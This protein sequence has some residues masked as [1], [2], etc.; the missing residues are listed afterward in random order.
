MSENA[1]FPERAFQAAQNL[2]RRGAEVAKQQTRSVSLQRQIAKAREQKRRVFMQMGLKVY[3]L[4][5]KELVKNAELRILCQQVTSL[6]AEI[7]L[8]EE[9]LDQLRRGVPKRDTEGGVD[10]EDGLGPD[11]GP[12]DRV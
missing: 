12:P 5:Q 11:A 10:E 8:R 9:E 6:D 1:D 7:E 3:A 4:H 2:F